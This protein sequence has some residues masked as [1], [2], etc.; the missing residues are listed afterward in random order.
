[1]RVC[2]GSSTFV[3]EGINLHGDGYVD[4]LDKLLGLL[5]APSKDLDQLL[6]HSTMIGPC[7]AGALVRI[8]LAT[9][10]AAWEATLATLS[11]T[12]II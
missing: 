3:S 6:W 9:A 11:G 12:S 4:R 5:S 2:T 10:D 8:V 1:M 7:G